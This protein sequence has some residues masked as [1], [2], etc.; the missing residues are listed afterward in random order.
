MALNEASEHRRNS[1][2]EM[3]DLAGLG[4]GGQS[5]CGEKLDSRGDLTGFAA[6][7]SIPLALLTCRVSACALTD[8]EDGLAGSPEELVSEG[9]IASGHA[10]SDLAAAARHLESDPINIKLLMAERITRTSGLGLDYRRR[11]VG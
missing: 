9:A 5:Q 6:G 8:E 1:T 11:C 7:F 3:H 2:S 4:L 10:V